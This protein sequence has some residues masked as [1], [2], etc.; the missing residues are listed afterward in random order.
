M[1][2]LPTQPLILH[3]WLQKL[4]FLLQ[5]QTE[6]LL[7]QQLLTDKL[8]AGENPLKFYRSIEPLLAGPP[9]FSDSIA[10]SSS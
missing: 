2:S 9:P 8:K 3:L 5:I 10:A 6:L 1:A 7:Q 4:Q